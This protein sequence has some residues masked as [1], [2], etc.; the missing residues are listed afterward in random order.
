MEPN[1]S[2]VERA[3]QLAKTGRYPTVQDIKQHLKKEGYL[4]HYIE[5]RTLSRQL[6]EIIRDSDRSAAMR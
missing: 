2:A 6:R 3:F 1:V 4:P 5:G